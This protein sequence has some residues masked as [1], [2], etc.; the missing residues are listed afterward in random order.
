MKRFKLLFSLFLLMVGTVVAYA[1][2]N[3]TA[4]TPLAVNE[5]PEG[6]YLIGSK[7][8]SAF[9]VTNPF[10]APNGSAMRLIN[11][12]EVTTDVATSLRGI[13]KIS[14]TT[15]GAK[16]T[17]TSME[18]QSKSWVSG[19]AC[20]LGSSNIV[21]YYNINYNSAD[22]GYYTFNGAGGVDKNNLI[23]NS[24]DVYA[25]SATE[26]GRE[27]GQEMGK[28][29]LIPVKLV[30]LNCNYG[31]GSF[32]RRYA[33]PVDANSFTPSITFYKDFSTVNLEDNKESYDVTCT[34]DF[35]FEVDKFC[36]LTIR[37][38]SQYVFWDTKKG[39]INTGKSASEATGMGALWRFEHVANTYNQVKLYSNAMGRTMAVT[40]TDLNTNNSRAYL[41]QPNSGYANTFVVSL[42]GE[43]F[44]LANPNN[45]N[46]N[47]NDINGKVDVL[48][49]S[50]G[51]WTDGGSK[52]D[53]GSTFKVVPVSEE[54]QPVKLNLTSLTATDENGKTFTQSL[55]GNTYYWNNG[56][57]IAG[58][59]LIPFYKTTSAS[60]SSE[61]VVMAVVENNF[62]FAVSTDIN[63]LK[64]S[65][66]FTR[67]YDNKNAYDIYNGIVE[68]RRLYVGVSNGFNGESGRSTKANYQKAD[69]QDVCTME[70]AFMKADDN[71]PYHFY[72]YNK[73]TGNFRLTFSST[74]NKTNG[75][76]QEGDG[77]P[78][79]IGPNE[80]TE[81]NNGFTMR[82]NDDDDNAIGD[83]NSGPLAYWSDRRT[84]SE[85]RDQG[86]I[87]HVVTDGEL[88]DACKTLVNGNNKVGSLSANTKTAITAKTTMNDFLV[89]YNA[90]IADENNYA[91]VEASNKLYRIQ[92]VRG[93][94]YV[95]N[96]GAYADAN[97]KVS[98]NEDSRRIRTVGIATMNTDISSVVALESTGTN[99]VYRIKNLNSGFYW[100]TTKAGLNT[101]LFMTRETQ[102][103][104]NYRIGYTESGRPGY[105]AF[106]DNDIDK[107]YK[108][109][110]SRFEEANNQIDN[111]ACTSDFGGVE[112]AI[113]FFVNEAT[114]YPIVFKNKYAT[115]NLPFDV[116]L[117]SNVKA[118]V[119]EDV[120]N[121][122]ENGY[123]EL[124]LKDIQT[125]VPANTPVV[126]ECT[127]EN[128]PTTTSAVTIDF[129]MP[130]T[131]SSY[132]GTNIL[133]GST[134]KRT[135]FGNTEYY[136]LANKPL[137]AE[138]TE[139]TTAFFRVG[140]QEM[141]ANKVFLLKE[142]VPAV[143]E[144]SSL[145][146]LFN[147]DGANQT[148]GIDNVKDN[149]VNE[150]DVYYDLNGHRVFYPAH[151]IYVKGNGQKVFIK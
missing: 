3:L 32:T 111:R 142:R 68:S 126:L 48:V 130:G 17:I 7:S 114:T 132:T 135:G 70:W 149:N 134:V 85:L 40:F 31:K 104:G 150:S 151:G 8:S 30:T 61:G 64:Y 22:G 35:P 43:G 119:I 103:A 65:A 5:V 99:G 10:I 69:V 143:A 15:D 91:P 38:N 109:L 86:S 125:T 83:H 146:L 87:F 131:V 81:F 76:M 20:P 147:F 28:W 6:Y 54:D 127:N 101:E 139:N 113:L 66:L 141:P 82:L 45:D 106:I 2:D 60:I 138:D 63:D 77:T 21:G 27:S 112:P 108:Y 12:S 55:S 52:T 144:G 47:L 59:E 93:N 80:F 96:T 88:L 1:A 97:G 75:L 34:E 116:T 118:Y 29:K 78:I 107:D 89:A 115:T 120:S 4:V 129:T 24:G 14:K 25:K 98:E 51:V 73:S 110:A 41:T 42:L 105:L 13:W 33:A 11:G 19:P 56:T 95:A 100:G 102:Y 39:Y 94:L 71:N 148:T 72:V 67:G 136:A 44:R 23:T 62:P 133:S 37:G 26:F 9:G 57:D 53:G 128:A 79:V 58:T 46:A 117:P 123:R 137:T 122:A 140:T 145:A 18:D 49:R 16:Y 84:E 124:N 90:A 36:K 92:P 74:D 50:L 121:N